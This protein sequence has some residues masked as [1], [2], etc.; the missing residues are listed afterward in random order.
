MAIKISI[1]STFDDS[2][3]K[4]AAR[5]FA[6]AESAIG[7][8]KAVLGGVA[9]IADAASLALVAGGGYAVKAASDQEQAFGALESIYGDS[10]K[11]M[12][13]WAK[14]S[15]T[16]GASAAE[17]AQGA[18]VLGAAFTGV[19]MS[20]EKAAETSKLVIARASD[21]AATFGGSTTDA[22]SSFSAALRGEFDPLERYGVSLRAADLDARALSMGLVKAEGDQHKI[23]AATVAAE[24]AQ[25]AAS[26]A[27]KTYGKDS[28][29]ARE[30]SAK[31]GLAQD[32][33][34]DATGGTVPELTAAQKQLAAL[35]IIMEQTGSSSGAASRELD[36]VAGAT[37]QA[38]ADIADAAAVIGDSLAPVVADIAGKLADMAKWV[39]ANSDAAKA[40]VGG[41][42]ALTAAVKLTN[43]AMSVYQTV[44]SVVNILTKK[45]GDSSK[46][47]AKAVDQDTAALKRNTDAEVANA[48]A[49]KLGDSNTRRHIDAKGKSGKASKVLAQADD[50]AAGSAG[51]VAVA[52]EKS[53]AKFGVKKAASVALTGAM[54]AVP[55]VAAASAAKTLADVTGGTARAEQYF[56]AQTDRT[57]DAIARLQSPT[58][59]S[60]A[61]V[62]VYGQEAA[63]ASPKVQGVGQ[64]S[65]YAAAQT[66]AM[67][68]KAT[69]AKSSVSALGSTS[70]SAR[71][72]IAAAEVAA[73]KAAQQFGPM[74]SQAKAAKDNVYRL[75]SEAANASGNLSGMSSSASRAGSNARDLGSKSAGAKGSVHDLGSSAYGASGYLGGMAGQ[76][77][78]AADNARRTGDNA[79]YATAQLQ[80]M[81]RYTQGSGGW[82]SQYGQAHQ[83]RSAAPT[84]VN[85]TGALDPD[86]VARQ[87]GRLLGARAR[88]AG[89]ATSSVPAW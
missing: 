10:A 35:D 37:Q 47:A 78:R 80:A 85:I 62:G 46:A 33:L 87:V 74:S 4:K 54:K 18:T 25:R 53:A 9:P 82:S 72:G 57:K 31:L 51:K 67:A 6:K 7:K 19:G 26:D 43:A 88:R 69:S 39:S 34:K 44:S 58:R 66:A 36:T 55:W 79:R 75:R 8:T 50:V 20:Q 64:Q 2:G 40:A 41:I 28:I 71:S 1:L 24:K 23:A 86:A 27:I 56:A 14:S 63:K 29:Q 22:L 42:A 70:S 17:A 16:I 3:I 68:G 84:T 73:R 83:M 65:G 30:A 32:R 11:G 38:K 21:M 52:A 15:A 5:E 13:D 81:S 76:A 89:T 48:A 59:S 60:A 49:E 45:R 61:A 77:S 12:Q